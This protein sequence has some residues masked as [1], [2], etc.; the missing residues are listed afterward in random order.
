MFSE[1]G[2]N[3]KTEKWVWKSQEDPNC[4]KPGIRGCGIWAFSAGIRSHESVLIQESQMLKFITFSNND[5][6]MFYP[7]SNMNRDVRI[8]FF[9]ILQTHCFEILILVCFKSP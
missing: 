8:T 6:S 9:L 7:H 5:C 2:S 4:E 1:L 3:G